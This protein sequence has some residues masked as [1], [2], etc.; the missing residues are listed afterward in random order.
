MVQ[1]PTILV[2]NTTG[3][4]IRGVDLSAKLSYKELEE[5]SLA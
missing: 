1:V 2:T 5:E 3:S 4:Y